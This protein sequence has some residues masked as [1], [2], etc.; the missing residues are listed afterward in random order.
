MDIRKTPLEPDTHYHIYNRGINGSPVFFESKNYDFFLKQY[1]K[2]IDPFVGTY[3]Y[4][5]LGNHFHLLIRVRP[6]EE[7][8]PLIKD[9]P[10]YWHVSNGFSSFL[11]SYTRAMN[12]VYDRTGALF[13]TPYKRIAVTND[14]YFSQL[15]AYIHF[16]PIKHG[17]VKDI[18]EYPYSSYNTHL[19]N[20]KTKLKR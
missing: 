1:A 7:L 11:Q 6:E 14:A 9:K 19:S 18:D 2:Y 12:K 8:I 20:S 3:A 16:N 10:C 15:V 5:L 17:F 4:C 13:E